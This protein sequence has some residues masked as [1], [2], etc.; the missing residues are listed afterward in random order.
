[1]KPSGNGRLPP[2]FSPY[3]GTDPPQNRRRRS[4]GGHISMHSVEGQGNSVRPGEIAHP[5]ANMEAGFSSTPRTRRDSLEIRRSG[6][7]P[8]D[9]PFLFDI[10]LCFRSEHEAI[11]VSRNWARNPT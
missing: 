7:F 2:Q 6:Y 1:M 11:F 9:I 4:R 8:L 5:E 10:F 3:S